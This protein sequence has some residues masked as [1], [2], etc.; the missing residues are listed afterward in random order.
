M[1]VI[2]S[3]KLRTKLAVLALF[4][5]VCLL[6]F[7]TVAV[8]NSYEKN[9]QISEESERILVLTELSVKRTRSDGGF[10]RK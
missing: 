8:L 1:K 9:T 7:E 3:M 6:Y 4:P 2:D 10:H 5:L